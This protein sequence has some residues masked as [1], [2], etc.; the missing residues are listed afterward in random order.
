[1]TALRRDAC[2]QD[3]PDRADHGRVVDALVAAA[4][5]RRAL[6]VR[7]EERDGAGRERA[8]ARESRLLG[9]A[10][11]GAATARRPVSGSD[12]DELRPPLG[13]IRVRVGEGVERLV[14]LDGELEGI[15]G[16]VKDGDVQ[17]VVRRTPRQRHIDSVRV[18]VVELPTGLEYGAVAVIVGLLVGVITL[19]ISHRRGGTAVR[20]AGVRPYG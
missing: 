14:R 19:S 5:A 17:T 2:A 15:A 18:P 13:G 20:P 12:I 7:D 4:S 3:A 6:D 8:H 11:S 9:R 16:V 10:V 1:M